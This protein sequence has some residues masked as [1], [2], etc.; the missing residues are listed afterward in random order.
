MVT[1]HTTLDQQGS[2]AAQGWG[3][4]PTTPDNPLP[5]IQRTEMA[6]LNNTASGTTFDRAYIGSQV[7]DHQRT[8]SIVDAA[9]NSAQRP[10]LRAMLQ[11]QVRPA[12][13]AHLARA[14]SIQGRIGAP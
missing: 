8:L 9:I 6:T 7:V 14:Q 3:L 4:A 5:N 1:D 2:T 10:E 12:V 11:N 13:A